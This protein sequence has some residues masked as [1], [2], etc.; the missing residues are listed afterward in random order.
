MIIKN[1]KMSIDYL[2]LLIYDNQCKC[3]QTCYI[4]IK[5][6]NKLTGK[7]LSYVLVFFN[8]L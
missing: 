3:T 7:K 6:I 5:L 4:K 1:I 2:L 8:N